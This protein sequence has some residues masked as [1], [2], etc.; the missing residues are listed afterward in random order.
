M[1]EHSHV[2]LEKIEGDQRRGRILIFPRICDREI[3]V[4]RVSPWGVVISVKKVWV[5]HDLM[6]DLAEET[7]RGGVNAY[8]SVDDS[9]PC[10]C[11]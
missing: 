10:Q 1:K 7:R 3:R 11:A 9:P 5:I 4:L 2:V 6:F 8:I